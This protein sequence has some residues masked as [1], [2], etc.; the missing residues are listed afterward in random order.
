M[1]QTRI[2][3][4]AIDPPQTI[5][6]AQALLAR[7]GKLDRMIDVGETELQDA[8]AGLKKLAADLVAPINAD[9]ES[10]VRALQA[11][12]EVNRAEI[13]PKPKRSIQWPSGTVGFRDTPIAVSVSKAKTA[14]ICAE[15]LKR[16]LK[17]CLRMAV[18]LDKDALKKVRKKVEDIDGLRF[19]SRTEFFA[20]PNDTKVEHVKAVK[21]AKVTRKKA[22][23][24]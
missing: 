7:I 22:K 12:V 20:K 1:T 24:K 10:S 9:I 14:A 21:P 13:I 8:I 6:E 15:L 18:S 23:A 11:Y 3:A 19:T 4:T 17:Q 5:E 16:K 2:K